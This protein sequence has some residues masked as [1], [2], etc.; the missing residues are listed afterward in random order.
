[1]GTYMNLTAFGE[2]A[3]AALNNAENRITELV[4]TTDYTASG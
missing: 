4:G 1:M 3:E 2:Q